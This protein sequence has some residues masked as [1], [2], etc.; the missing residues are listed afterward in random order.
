M[1]ELLS[2]QEG[3]LLSSIILEP[4]VL[5]VVPFTIPPG[6]LCAMI[7]DDAS[8][9]RG[10]SFLKKLKYWKVRVGRK[11]VGITITYRKNCQKSK[12]HCPF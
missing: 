3:V 5:K 10:F 4:F 12:S 7:E 8:T 2:N 9:L 1:G 6:S 11:K